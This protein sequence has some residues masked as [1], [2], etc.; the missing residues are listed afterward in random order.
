MTREQL[1]DIAKQLHIP[2]NIFSKRVHGLRQNGFV[3]MYRDDTIRISEKGWE[4][5][6]KEE[7]DSLVL[8]DKKTDGYHRLVIFDIPEKRR[9]AR[10]I[11]REKVKEF[12]CKQVQKSVYLTK[13]VCDEEINRLATLLRIRQYVKVFKL[14]P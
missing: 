3:K 5:I 11:F 8:Q 10:I 6:V 4:R 13:Y 7:I 14:F 2:R 9:N 1:R 12:E